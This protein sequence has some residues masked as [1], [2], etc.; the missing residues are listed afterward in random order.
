MLLFTI[1]CERLLH[2]KPVSLIVLY[3]YR[4]VQNV[5]LWMLFMNISQNPLLIVTSQIQILKPIFIDN[6]ACMYGL[7]LF[8]AEI[9]E[10]VCYSCHLRYQVVIL[11]TFH[12]VTFHFVYGDFCQKAFFDKS[13]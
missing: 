11:F 7:D 12:I 2:F 3:I 4:L 6:N 1:F 13:F 8:R 9:A 5:Q 10:K